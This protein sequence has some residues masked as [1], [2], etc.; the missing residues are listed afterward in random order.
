MGFFAGAM[1][2]IMTLGGKTGNKGESRGRGESASGGES[3]RDEIR[4]TKKGKATSEMKKDE[5]NSR[6]KRPK[7]TY[8]IQK[9]TDAER[10]APNLSSVSS[11]FVIQPNKATGEASPEESGEEEAAKAEFARELKE[12]KQLMQQRREKADAEAKA[13][14]GAEP[15]AEPTPKAR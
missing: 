14:R 3:G 1:V 5:A 11:A 15:N 10:N 6:T 13:A 12:K 9:I 2:R 4:A 8:E 7:P